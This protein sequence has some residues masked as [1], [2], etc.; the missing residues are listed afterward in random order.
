MGGPGIFPCKRCW[1]A[2]SC[3]G[4]ILRP[5]Q[6]R[7][8][9]RACSTGSATSFVFLCSRLSLFGLGSSVLGPE[10]VRS[11]S[12]FLPPGSSGDLLWVVLLR[13]R[14]STMV[15]GVEPFFPP[16]AF[17]WDSVSSGFGSIGD[18]LARFEHKSP[19]P[20]DTVDTP[21]SGSSSR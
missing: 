2:V 8:I 21:A 17:L 18:N 11:L 12:F 20:D 10:G 3:S 16:G 7:T 15:A 14:S 5:F 6:P 9:K 19:R 1:E 4:L 13:L